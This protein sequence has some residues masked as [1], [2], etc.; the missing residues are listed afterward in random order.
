MLTS[1][2]VRASLRKGKL[3]PRYLAEKDRERLR[4]VAEA[5]IHAYAGMVGASKGELD[6]AAARIPHGTR[7]RPIVLGLRKLCEDRLE[8]AQ[9]SELDPAR[10]REVVF[11][12]SAA[13]HRE[14]AP[15]DRERA[16]AAAA[17]ELGCDVATL[18]RALFADL[19]DAQVVRSFT[20]IDVDELFARYDLSLAQATLLRATRLVVRFRESRPAVLRALFRSARFH[21]L[22]YVVRPQADGS[23]VL[24]LDGP[25]SLFEAVQKYGLKLA[26]F[27]PA[28]LALESF[29]LEASLLWGASRAAATFTL[30][31]ADGLVA[32]PDEPPP[33]PE[34]EALVAAFEKL[35]SPWSAAPTDRILVAR[36]GSAIVPD[37]VFEHAGTG[38]QVFLELFGFWSRASVF[39]RIEQIRAGLPARLILVAGKQ[40]RV[41]EELL[42]EGEHGS[43]LYLFKTAISAKEVLARLGISEPEEPARVAKRGPKDGQNTSAQT[44]NSKQKKPRTP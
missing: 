33:R 35:G 13:Q 17:A 32:A 5:L 11:T 38:E 24:E 4:G 41:S 10:A 34:L 44:H 19:K 37:L 39:R 9:E 3:T 7:D 36:D 15:F 31:N 30:S 12:I 22:L 23:F 43:S 2:L 27:L 42:E 6:E 26:V 1:D 16:L 8:L 20:P 14:P 29:A 18:E 25:F 40:L 28:L 21:G